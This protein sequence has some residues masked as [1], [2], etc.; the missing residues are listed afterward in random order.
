MKPYTVMAAVL[1]GMLGLPAFAPPQF[2]REEAASFE[3]WEAFL[4]K[5]AFQD[6][7]QMKDRGA[8]A[9]PWIIDLRSPD[10]RGRG[11]WKNVIGSPKGYPENWKAEIA[12]YR[13][14]RLLE[15]DMVP[16][17]VEARFLGR[18]GSLQAWIEG[19]CT[20]KE[21]LEQN[22]VV[23]PEKGADWAR[24]FDLQ[25]AFDNLI[26][27][28]DRHQGNYLIT[29]DWRMILIDHSRALQAG[30][31][32][33]TGLIYDRDAAG[34]KAVYM[35]RLPR[36]FV[37]KLRAL[38]VRGLQAAVGPYLTGREIEAVLIRR[39]LILKCLD[40]RLREWGEAAVLY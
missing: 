26:A 13:L 18:P 19:T 8:L 36:A 33:D 40:E 9:E 20:L 35:I 37:A 23:P 3:A 12:A 1:V 24:L 16:P 28:Y 38:D 15:L 4:K 22:M 30:S 32:F 39:N 14:S 5:A 10:R 34:A 11:L 27:N 25:Q 21:L 7:R 31:R 17:T 29:S 2:T 6:F